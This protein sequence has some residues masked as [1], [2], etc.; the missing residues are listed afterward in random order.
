MKL[1]WN[2]HACFTLETEQGSVVFDPYSPGSVPGFVLP[3]LT[4]DAVICSH[5]HGDHSYTEGVGLSGKKPS[6][7]VSQIECFHD[8]VKGK[9]RGTNLI[10]VI[11][12]EGKR[13]A[14]FGDLGHQ[15]SKNQLEE[16]GSIDIAMLPV[17]GFYTIDAREA[18]RVCDAVSPKTV[19]P[20]HYRGE[21]FGYDVLGTVEPFLALFDGK[22]I[23]VLASNVWELPAEL[24]EG[25]V[26]FEK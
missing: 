6:F 5:G 21:S 13:I 26:V 12:A 4:A 9:K 20:M 24:P 25:V 16:L 19:I 18:K 11:E 3:E 23:T 14:H 8:E 2:G 17:G 7:R 22:S 10:T 1:T 15:L